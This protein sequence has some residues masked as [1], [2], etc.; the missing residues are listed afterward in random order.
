LQVLRDYRRKPQIPLRKI[1]LAVIFKAFF[2]LKSINQLDSFLKTNDARRFFDSTHRKMVCSASTIERICR[3]TDPTQFRD[4]LRNNAYY[5]RDLGLWRGI[6]NKKIVSIDGSFFGRLFAVCL[7]VAGKAPCMLGY[8]PSKK[9]KEYTHA[10]E[11]IE[12]ELPLLPYGY[13]DYLVGDGLYLKVKFFL[14]LRK[15][16]TKG[17]VKYTPKPK[18][19]RPKILQEIDKLIKKTTAPDHSFTD[20]H[21]LQNVSMWV[22]NHRKLTEELGYF[23]VIKVKEESIKDQHSK[24]SQYYIIIDGDI[25]TSGKGRSLS[26]EQY[27]ELAKGAGR[28]AIEIEGFKQMNQLFSSKRKYFKNSTAMENILTSIM[29]SFN[30]MS[31]YVYKHSKTLHVNSILRHRTRLNILKR[32]HNSLMRHLVT[33]GLNLFE[34]TDTS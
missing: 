13:I 29:L 24:A 23:T 8:K 4:I 27:R 18:K 3:Y 32:L 19:K 6:K 31:L 15:Y 30:L 5:M 11:L 16:G 1:V 34:F 17:I 14:T 2:E 26:L 20:K 22:F 21:R 12:Q 28:W 7:L 25:S 10:L 9:G 33:R